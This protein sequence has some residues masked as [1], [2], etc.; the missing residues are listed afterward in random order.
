[1][2]SQKKRQ[3]DAVY[4]MYVDLTQTVKKGFE[5]VTDEELLQVIGNYMSLMDP[6]EDAEEISLT[7]DEIKQTALLAAQALS[8]QLYERLSNKQ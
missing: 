1:M 8:R 5:S 7:P 2:A 4:K 3:R 6:P